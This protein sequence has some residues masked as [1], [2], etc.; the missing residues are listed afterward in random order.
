VGGTDLL[1]EPGDPEVLLPL[2]LAAEGLGQVPGRLEP[3]APSVRREGWE[4]GL[5]LRLL[6]AGLLLSEVLLEIELLLLLLLLLLW[7]ELLLLRLWLELLLLRLWLELLLLWLWLE[8]L[9]WLWLELRPGRL[10]LLLRRGLRRPEGS[11]RV[12][13]LG[14]VEE[15]VDPVDEGLEEGA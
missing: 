8:G 13:E 15:C 3:R 9:L 12:P 6:E 2:Q 1:R 14:G 7:L 4:R 11:Q 5:R 10:E